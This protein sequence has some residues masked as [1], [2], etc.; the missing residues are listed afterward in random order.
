MDKAEFL[1]TIIGH[2]EDL[3]SE[4]YDLAEG[5]LGDPSISEGLDHA[6]VILE[7]VARLKD[8]IDS[9]KLMQ[10]RLGNQES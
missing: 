10:Y 6:I 8:Q 2:A 3:C 5:L 7:H 4:Y 1:G 9:L